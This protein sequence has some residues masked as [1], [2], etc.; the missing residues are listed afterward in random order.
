MQRI[1]DELIDGMLA[2]T[3]PGRSG[4]AFALPVPSL[5]IAE[6][7][8][9]PYAD[10]DFFQRSSSLVLGRFGGH[11]RRPGRPAVRLAAYL[12]NLIKLKTADP[13]GRRAV[14]RWRAGS[15]RAR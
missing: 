13:D 1:V 3:D 9:V 12:D 2:E 11:R 15:G 5:V 14:R 8:G 10:H 7:L 4:Q 6:L